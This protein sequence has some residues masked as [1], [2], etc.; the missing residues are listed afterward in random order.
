MVAI[1][2]KSKV[3]FRFSA[4]KLAEKDIWCPKIFQ[5]FLTSVMGVE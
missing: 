1:Q 2:D 4:Y 3:M 5:F